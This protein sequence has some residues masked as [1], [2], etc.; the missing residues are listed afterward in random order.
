MNLIFEPNPRKY[1]KAEY[2]SPFYFVMWFPELL[3][4][5]AAGGNLVMPG[6]WEAIGFMA[7]KLSLS[8]QH[9]KPLARPSAKL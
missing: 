2:L 8:G 1:E 9:L 4:K 5:V 7:F 3:G 6:T